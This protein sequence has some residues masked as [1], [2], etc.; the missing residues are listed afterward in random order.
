[1]IS[2]FGSHPA[3][4][5]VVNKM[6]TMIS[7]LVGSKQSNNNAA[8]GACLT[9]TLGEGTGHFSSGVLLY[10]PCWLSSFRNNYFN[11]TGISLNYKFMKVLRVSKTSK[12]HFV[13]VLYLIYTQAC[14]DL[15]F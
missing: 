9:G 14:V 10:V 6:L 11:M 7:A 13:L 5:R 3:G 12:K 15:G 2:Q 4:K 1:M 8:R